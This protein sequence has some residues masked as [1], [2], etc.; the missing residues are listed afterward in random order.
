MPIVVTCD[1][2]GKP[3]IQ[4][5]ANF[6]FSRAWNR[7]FYFCIK[8]LEELV[9]KYATKEEKN[10]LKKALEIAKKNRR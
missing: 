7:N 4:S 3:D 1:V 2:C 5:G 6:L 9:E 8:D 10:L